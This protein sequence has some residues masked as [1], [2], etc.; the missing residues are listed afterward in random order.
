LLWG[1]ASFVALQLGLAVAIEFWLPQLRDPFYAYKAARLRERTATSPRPFT[2]VML[3]TSRTTYGLKAGDLEQHLEQA[4]QRPVAAFNFGIPGA[5]PLTQLLALRRLL[6]EG[7]R[8]DVLLIEVLPPLLNGLLPNS[9][10]DRLPAH[11]LKLGELRLLARYGAPLPDLRRSWWQAW[12]VPWYS[13]RFAIISAAA[14]ALLSWQ[15]REDW[16]RCVDGHGWVDPPYGEVTPEK[17]RAGVVRAR[18]D[19]AGYLTNFR[20]GG[21]A[22]AALRELLALCGRE[23]IAPVLVLMP[24]GSDFRS[25]YGA[26]HWAEIDTFLKELQREYDVPL[27]DARE[28]VRDEDFADSHH[29]LPQGADVFTARLSSSLEELPIRAAH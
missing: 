6:A 28:W 13:H 17:Q 20:V 2:V 21:P 16:F 29:L 24:E 25:W 3:G 23:K 15:I 14:P 27:I 18:N 10:F 9:E 26:E 8:T 22:C 19:Y 1:L 4:Q 7:V 12:P 11:R 5:G